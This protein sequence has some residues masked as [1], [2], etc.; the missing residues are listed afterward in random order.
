MAGKKKVAAKTLPKSFEGKTCSVAAHHKL[1]QFNIEFL[2][3]LD[4]QGCYDPKELPQLT[5]KQLIDMY[6]L[7]VLARIFDDKAVKL[8][9]QGRLGTYA[10]IL[11]QEAAQIASA[12]A[13]ESRDWMFPSFRENASCIVRGMPMENILQY[14]G[15]DE[16]GHNYKGLNNFPIA[17]PISTQELHAVGVALAAKIMK[18]NI[19]ALVYFG[20]GGTSEGDFHEALNFAGVY[21]VPVVFFC[22]NNQWA[23]S[24]P[25]EQQTHSLTLAQKAIAYGIKGM[26]V[27]GNDLF[28]VYKAT[29]QA[30][31]D[32]K[33]GTPVLIE[34]ITYRMADHTTAD[35]AK[36]YRP[37]QELIA[38]KKKDPITRIKQYLIEKKLWD[39]KKDK[40]LIEDCENK[41]KAAV[42]AY[43]NKQKPQPAEFFDYTFKTLTPQLQEQKKELEALYPQTENEI[44][45]KEEGSFP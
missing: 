21:Q 13:L 18:D 28:A 19:A 31:Q 3:I 29:K 43:E 24:V 4:E 6:R 23:I 25:R 5:P 12:Y 36:R 17:I 14:W 38:W 22:Q 42:D 33:K 45:K 20:D 32:A 15:G 40:L 39:E 37:E 11:G 10:S 44:I 26:Q 16:R 41:V 27:D 35:D 7:M 34:A 9:R 2:Q 30:L 8:Q 1:Y